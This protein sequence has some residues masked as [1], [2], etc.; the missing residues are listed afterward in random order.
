MFSGG[1]FLCCLAGYVPRKPEGAHTRAPSRGNRPRQPCKE[2]TRRR[3]VGARLGLRPA[4]L[5]LKIW[6]V[7]LAAFC[8][9]QRYANLDLRKSGTALLQ[10]DG[11]RIQRVHF[12]SRPPGLGK[13]SGKVFFPR[14]L[15][16][17][18]QKPATPRPVSFPILLRG[19]RPLKL[20]TRKRAR[21]ANRFFNR[22]SWRFRFELLRRAETVFPKTETVTPPK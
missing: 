2:N 22:T 9:G 17:G 5:P 8:S 14:I 11:T 16:W 3:P 19:P 6:S 4:I 10:A 1:A 18:C 20:R 12:Y 7:F 21:L 15:S 13:P